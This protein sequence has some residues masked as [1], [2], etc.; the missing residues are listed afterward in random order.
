MIK[1]LTD[2]GVLILD[3]AMG[4]MLQ[5]RGLR[6]GELPETWNLTRPDDITDI[7]LA[8]LR[9][10]CD[11]LSANTFGANTLKFSPAKL[12]EI[13]AA[14]IAHAREA[15]TTYGEGDR[16][17]ALDMGP[18]GK[19]L[20]PYGD[21]AF[22]D[23]VTIYRTTAALGE[24]YGADLILIETMNDLSETRA[25]VIGAKEATSL[26]IMVSNAYSENGKLMTGA[27]VTEIIT[28]LEGLGAEVIGANCS[29]GPRELQKTV[30]EML[31]CSSVPTLFMPNAGLPKLVDGETVYDIDPDTFADEVAA[32][33]TRGVRVVG[34]CC[35]TTPAHIEAVAKRVRGITPAPLC[36]NKKTMI[37]S[38]VRSVQIG[39]LPV[40]IGERINPTGKRRFKQ[41]LIEHDIAY[42][43]EEGIRQEG[44]GAH[45]LDVNVG[46][47][48]VDEVS[49]LPDVITELQA[50]VDLPLQ[51]DTSNPAAM[52]RALRCYNGKALINSVNGKEESMNAVFP[53]V[54]KY[55]GVVVCLTLDENGIPDTAEGR[56]EI[57]K[58]IR[59]R[60][61]A[62][63]IDPRDLIF[64]TLCMTIST[65]PKAAEIT[66]DAL[67][68][69]HE[70]LGGHTVLGISNVSF[71]LPDRE[72]VNARFLSYALEC[73]LSCAIINPHSTPVMES[74]CG[75]VN[76][77]D[78]VCGGITDFANEM[79]S[80]SFRDETSEGGL[81]GYILHGQ[82]AAAANA[83]REM[84]S[85]RAPLE[86]VNEEV[87]PALDTVGGLYE[88]GKVYLPQLLMSA[89]AAKAA[90]EVI[91]ETMMNTADPK[92][93]RGKFVLATV[94]GDIHD[95]GKNIVKLLMENYGFEVIDLGRDV[96]VEAIVDKVVETHAGLCGLSALMTTTVPAMEATVKRLRECASWCRVVVGGA[97]LNEEYAA[98]M[99]ADKYAKDALATVR[100]AEEVYGNLTTN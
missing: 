70:R 34:G 39:V 75:Y 30:G 76:G 13:I 29:F 50:V 21:L 87:I 89:E 59:D 83:V 55:G 22:E 91:K 56:Y 99:G 48:D 6:P 38:G 93:K 46:I 25:A 18:T 27:S 60:A 20:A 52:E 7:H 79:I 61:I 74:Y 81:R 26:P 80:A 85:S 98:K 72:T 77:T 3:G 67:K 11:I 24:K 31:T 17:V 68:M 54:K 8:Y 4:T 73:G 62:Y 100:Y 96:P 35:G 14:A 9:A 1:E 40:V 47:P 63:G 64:D 45:V 49:L 58:R 69:V 28:T 86:I 51:I 90:F 95:I 37:S 12:E 65:N 42:V 41:A 57:A 53:L 66:T 92:A 36:D 44:A 82:K 15:I 10:G 5:A 33:V 71:G 43:L 19:L 23:A 78:A 2:R 16:Y 94:Q 32:M 97:V 88:G 84:L